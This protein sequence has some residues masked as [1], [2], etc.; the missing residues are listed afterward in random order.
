MFLPLII[1]KLG[2]PKVTLTIR[3]IKK[4]Q[5]NSYCY[6]TEVSKSPKTFPYYIKP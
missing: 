4:P 1:T 6:Q 5:T 3:K 2:V